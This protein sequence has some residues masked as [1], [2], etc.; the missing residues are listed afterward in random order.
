MRRRRLLETPRN[1]TANVKRVFIVACPRSGTTWLHLLFA[2]HPGVATTRE[3]HLF[4][5]YLG[6]LYRAWESY[7]SRSATVG[8]TL[9]LSDEEFHGLCRDF[10]NAVLNKISATND[11]ATVIVE[12]TPQHVRYAP[13]IL[14]L[15]PDAYFI[16]IV[17][18]PRSVVSSLRAA[19][20][21]W[22]RRWASASIRTNARL[23]CSEVTAGREICDLTHRYREVQFEAIKGEHGAEI[24]KDLFT[25]L[26]LSADDAFVAHALEACQ[27]ENVRDR[28]DGIRS[29][30]RLKPH[31]PE[32]LRKGAVD[33]WKE[34]LSP[35]E[36]R[37]IEY[38]AKDL[39]Q[40]YGYEP[41]SDG[42]KPKKSFY[43]QMA[44]LFDRVDWRARAI[45]ENVRNSL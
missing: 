17:R 32:S 30:M 24:V 29:Y 9:L 35:G 5:E 39:M 6:R 31:D 41:I 4:D 23:W 45:L 21:S 12:K 18:D 16:H 8:L 20:Q 15:I 22:G 43:L 19:A 3:T 36:I 37:T 38:I 27:I 1:P 14:K 34:D 26:E 33:S 42:K 10:A 11:S 2:Q 25:W 7:R 13:F 40:A 28:G 44:D